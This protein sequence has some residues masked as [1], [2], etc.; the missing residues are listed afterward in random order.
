[1]SNMADIWI[2]QSKSDALRGTPTV[3]VNPAAGSFVRDALFGATRTWT[4]GLARHGVESKEF[5]H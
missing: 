2:P 4:R 1:M 3:E 5:T